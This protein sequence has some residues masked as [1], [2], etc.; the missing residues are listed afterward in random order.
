MHR[1]R[2]W[3]PRPRRRARRTLPLLSRLMLTAYLLTAL[4]LAGVVVLAG[5]TAA[6]WS[7]EGRLLAGVPGRLP[8]RLSSLPYASLIQRTASAQGLD[9]VLVAAVVEVESGFNPLAVSPKGARGLMQIIAPTWQELNPASACRGDHPPPVREKGC[10]YDPAANLAS[11]TRYLRSLLDRFAGDVVLALAAYNAGAEAVERVAPPGGSGA[12][13]ALAETRQYTEA[14][15]N[16]WTRERVGLSYAQARAL[17]RLL[18]AAWW[19]LAVDAAVL[20]MAFAV[21][22]SWAGGTRG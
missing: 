10:I 17:P 8:T 18:R 7:S 15:L 20:G 21:R 1:L 4:A 16:R 22:P 3:R 11:G 12:V 13:L 2:R 9:P 19:L 14:V 6:S 5:R